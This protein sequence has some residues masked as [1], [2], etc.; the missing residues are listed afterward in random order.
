MGAFG[1]RTAAVWRRAWARHLRHLEAADGLAGALDAP[2]P[3]QRFARFI[4]VQGWA[5]SVDGEPVTIVLEA[6]GREVAEIRANAPRPDVGRARPD[7]QGSATSGFRTTLSGTV[8]PTSRL[9]WLVV[10]ARTQSA[11]RT[12]YTC[13]IVRSTG[14]ALWARHAYRE[15]WDESARCESHARLA[16]AGSVDDGEWKRSGEST[17]DHVAALAQIGPDDV[18]LE[19]GCGAGRVGAFLAPRC[20]RWIGADVSPRMLDHARAALADLSNVELAPVSGFELT[21]FDAGSIDVVYC[22]AVFMHLDEWDRYRYMQEAYRVL[23]PGGRIYFDNFCLGSPKG[24]ELFEETARLDPAARP[25]NVSKSSTGEELQVYA[26]KAG[27]KNIRL[28]R[29]ELFVTLVAEKPDELTRRGDS[30]ER[31]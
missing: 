31:R 15:V 3:F 14:K 27:Y 21:G 28:T 23:R 11:P 9:I 6:G 10:K 24:W 4:D 30:T 18:V 1:E 19:I 20:R 13:P 17:A 16:V 2:R 22:T 29:G 7:L 12:L 26:E 25:P 5:C 8:L